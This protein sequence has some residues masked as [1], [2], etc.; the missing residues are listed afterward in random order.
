MV[1]RYPLSIGHT[2]GDCIC[3]F[4][5]PPVANAFSSAARAAGLGNRSLYGLRHGGASEDGASG[6]PLP[7]IQKRGRSKTY[8]SVTRYN[9]S[10]LLQEARVA[11]PACVLQFLLER[12]VNLF[13]YITIDTAPTLPG[14]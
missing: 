13:H 5:Y 2:V 3:R 9:K 6:V 12:D 11:L 8:S 4:E 1:R 10:G 7:S 14:D